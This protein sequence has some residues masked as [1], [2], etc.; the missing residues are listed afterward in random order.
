MW[1]LGLD[2]GW[3]WNDALEGRLRI[4]T[5]SR[6]RGQDQKAHLC[7]RAGCRGAPGKCHP[8]CSSPGRGGCGCA[9]RG[10]PGLCRCRSRGTTGTIGPS[11]L[12]WG[13]ETPEESALGSWAPRSR[14]GEGGGLGLA[15]PRGRGAGNQG[16][17][18]ESLIPGRPVVGST[19]D[20][21]APVPKETCSEMFPRQK[22]TRPKPQGRWSSSP[23]LSLSGSAQ[24][25]QDP[26]TALAH[27]SKPS[28][29]PCLIPG[30]PSSNARQ[31]PL[32]PSD[33]PQMPPP[34]GSP[35]RLSP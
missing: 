31:S 33:P 7:R 6:V 1:G 25:P 17:S 12:G 5:R 22:Y 34:P 23:N 35:P 8:Q 21:A 28:L 30:I 9:K 32:H 16:G 14:A 15:L 4:Q 26:S 19:V 10:E 27:G 20:P 11:H 2:A 29:R 24:T 18:L 13:E 3:G